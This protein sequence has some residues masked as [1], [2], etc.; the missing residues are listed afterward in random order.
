MSAAQPPDR[1]SPTAS[2][3]AIAALIGG[4]AGATLTARSSRLVAALST[5][6]GATLLTVAKAFARAGR[7]PIDN[8]ALWYRILATGA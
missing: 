4:A 2:D 8:Q 7:R 5:L 6:G 1:A 3:L